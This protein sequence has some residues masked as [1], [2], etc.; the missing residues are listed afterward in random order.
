M[1]ARALGDVAGGLAGFLDPD[2]PQKPWRD[3]FDVDSPKGRPWQRVLD[4]SA[5][6][7][8]IF[9]NSL[10]RT[11]NE[12][13]EK[14]SRDATR[15]RRREGSV[16]KRVADLQAKAAIATSPAEADELRRLAKQLRAAE[17]NRLRKGDLLVLEK[18]LEEYDPETGVLEV[19]QA[20]VAGLLGWGVATVNVALHR[21]KHHGYLDWTRRTR[22]DESGQPG[23][24]HKQA[25]SGYFFDW[26]DAM[27]ARTWHRFW[28]LVR[29]GLERIGR[30]AAAK[31]AA[32]FTRVFVPPTGER[33]PWSSK[34][35]GP[36]LK[37]VA[38]RFE[39]RKVR[40][41]KERK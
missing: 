22:L 26:K 2:R 32:L 10:N 5:E 14:Q 24:P 40:G 17:D 30:A 1:S 38:E 37:R 20:S 3:S 23:W 31:A 36:R 9:K 21:L 34:R 8:R 29:R 33:K 25:I 27:P 41:E 19:A 7:W 13:Y 4:G 39:R 12:D 16:S 18:F 6:T 11:C 35:P 15:L 28:Q